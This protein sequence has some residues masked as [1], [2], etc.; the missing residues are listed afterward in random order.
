MRV[1][2]TSDWH[3]GQE[4]HE[5]SRGPEH[6]VFLDWLV[7]RIKDTDADAL[8]VTGD[9]YDV[10]NPP[11]DAQQRLYRF[12]RAALHESHHLQIVIIGGNHD[13]AS[14]IELPK[15][16]VDQRRVFLIG[17]MPRSSG[18]LEPENTIFELRDRTGTPTLA[19][20]AVPFLRAGDLAAS[21]PEEDTVAALY[22]SV[23]Q[24]AKRKLAD[25]PIIVTGHLHVSGGEVS[26]LS[27]RRI[28]VGG[29]EAVSACIFAPEI[30]YVA[31]GHL[32][33][34]QSVNGRTTIRY[35]G[36][37]FPMS[38]AERDY[39]HSIVL[40]EFVDGKLSTSLIRTPRPIQFLR[41]PEQ[42]A[43]PL[44]DVERALEQLDIGDIKEPFV[45][46]LEIAVSLD[47]AEPDLRRRID[48]ALAGKAVRITRVLRYTTG[49]GQ[50]LADNA[51][52]EEAELSHIEPMHV[53]SRKHAQEFGGDPP[54]EIQIA[55]AELLSAVSDS[56][57]ATGV[58]P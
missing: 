28:F 34:P 11:V 24:A 47:T 21:N 26:E 13:S 14:R 2:H 48:A 51:S 42:G 49:S 41:V 57:A 58:T 39:M 37:P 46:F 45:P 19:C 1:L 38:V 54:E 23:F 17:G 27:E 50:S 8:I 40:L 44:P 18:N 29:Q 35:A 5:H 7:Q 43:A 15:E 30:S 9:I 4:L 33:K 32:H 52:I 22:A 25:L 10:A 3:L 53:F 16:L 55:F 31:L 6:D 56:Q 12:L 36:S 20:A